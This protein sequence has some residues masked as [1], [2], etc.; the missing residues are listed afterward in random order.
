[1]IDC[2]ILKEND[3]LNDGQ[4]DR[5]TTSVFFVLTTLFCC[6][7]LTRTYTSTHP[8]R[9]SDSWS[10]RT[11]RLTTTTKR[12]G[13]GVYNSHPLGG[14]WEGA[15]P[16]PQRNF[17]ECSSKNYREVKSSRPKWP[18]GQNLGL[19]LDLG[20]KSFGLGLSLGLKHLASAW[21]RSAAEAP[22]IKKSVCRPQDIT[23]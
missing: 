2:D 11:G 15:V 18:R 20:L 16:S 7:R 14:V 3:S 17:F 21:P 6:R 1:M 10:N 23:Q 9:Q 13:E 8:H 5:R 12:C 4:T 22:A 19:G